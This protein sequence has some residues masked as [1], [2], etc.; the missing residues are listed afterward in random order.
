MN[1]EGLE[2]LGRERLSRNFYMREFLYSEIA[3]WNC[4]RNIPHHPE[5]AL[6]V[7]RQL[8][9]QLL[10]P[11]QETFG[12]IHVRSGYRSPEVNDFGN[13]HKLNCASNEKNY[14][15]HIWDYP[16]TDGY[17]GATACIVVPALVDYLER[18][19]SWTALAWWIHDHLPYSSLCFFSCLG[20]FNISWHEN[21]ERRIDSYAKPQGCLTRAGMANHGGSHRK[22]YADLLLSL[23]TPVAP[24]P[25]LFPVQPISS[26]ARPVSH[27]EPEARATSGDTSQKTAPTD[28]LEAV[29]YRAI[30]T[31]T[32]WRKAGGHASM[33]N[34]ISGR[35]GAAG[36]F[37]GTVRIRYE[38]HGEPLFVVV[39]QPGQEMGKL[40]RRAGGAG[41]GT[42]IVDIPVEDL[43]RFDAQG[44]AD[45][46]ILAG[47]FS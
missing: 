25:T 12:R 9:T 37:A 32:S 16:D 46:A 18:G 44:G 23:N 8:C 24:M 39:W 42:E 30:H 3:H 34:A 29:Q 10:E 14:A 2:F 1:Y 19:G 40:I 35:S 21:P 6:H 41:R 11:L 43:K 7:G 36:L 17:S 45:R 28:S 5:V 15:G 38:V 26:I 22:E 31:R 47:Y 33:E 20:A 4:L 13:R 27:A